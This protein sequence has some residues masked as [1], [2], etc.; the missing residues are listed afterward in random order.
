MSSRTVV[1]IILVSLTTGP[2]C[3]YV[4]YPRI[5]LPWCFA[6][7]LLGFP[8]GVL[9]QTWDHRSGRRGWWT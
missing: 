4:L 6:P 8:L 7:A 3:G 2:I 5:G 9:L 1:V